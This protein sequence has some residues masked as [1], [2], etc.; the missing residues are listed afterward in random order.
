MNLTETSK[1]IAFGVVILI[2]ELIPTSV[3]IILFRL[4]LKYC[5]SRHNDRNSYNNNNN[6]S[7]VN[8]QSTVSVFLDT[9]T[10]LDD[11]FDVET[12]V[13]EEEEN[14]VFSSYQSTRNLYYGKIY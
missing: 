5:C 8:V 2:W 6:S 10:S 1:F 3:V 7:N 9:E 13:D 12:Y 4:R 14:N 11:S